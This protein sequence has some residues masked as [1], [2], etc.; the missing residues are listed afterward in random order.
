MLSAIIPIANYENNASNLKKI[1]NLCSDVAIELLFVL[2]I[3]SHSY[4]KQLEQILKVSK[5]KN[6][7]CYFCAVSG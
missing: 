6:Y 4:S 1:I 2:D 7:K 5:I 3:D